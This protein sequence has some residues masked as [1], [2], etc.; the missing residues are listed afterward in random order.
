MEIRLLDKETALIRTI[1]EWHHAQW[2]HLSSRS[3]E[4]RIAELEEHGTEVPLT[5]VGFAGREPIGTASLLRSDLDIWPHLTPWLTSEYVL[6][7]FRL[8][9]VKELLYRE[10]IETAK[11]LNFNALYYWTRFRQDHFT[12]L[13]WRAIGTASPQFGPVTIMKLDIAA[14]R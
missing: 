4:D 10:A 3:I 1:A 11:R 6:P 13:G 12:N 9:N 5:L 7:E 2:R 8:G 14:G